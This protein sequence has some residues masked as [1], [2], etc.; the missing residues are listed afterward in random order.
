MQANTYEH[1]QDTNENKKDISEIKDFVAS[2]ENKLKKVDVEK[3]HNQ[4]EST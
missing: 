2:L 1:E 4:L 3:I